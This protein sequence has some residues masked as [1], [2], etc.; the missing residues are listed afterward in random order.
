MFKNKRVIRKFRRKIIKWYKQ[1]KR[2]F[3]WRVQ[4]TPYKVFISEMLLQQTNAE[5]VIDPYL[6]I[7]SD[8]ESF[9]ALSSADQKRLREVF[10]KVG[11]FYR[12]ERLIRASKQIIDDHQGS[13][14][15]DHEIIEGIYGV[16]DYICSSVLCFGFG[17][18]YA[19]VDSNIIRILSRV[20]NVKSEKKRPRNDK[21]IWNAAD[22]LLPK[23]NYI[24]F[25]YA[26]L[27]FAAVICTSRKPKCGTCP[28]NEMCFYYTQKNL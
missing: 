8:Y 13:L 16:G 10:E 9:L 22:Q 1:N 25:N 17:K 19:V 20:F 21:L 23:Y 24:D 5:K 11:L 6:K 26:L 3:P 15:A 4:R 28:M 18:R 12:S 2:D 14:P 7:T 27:D